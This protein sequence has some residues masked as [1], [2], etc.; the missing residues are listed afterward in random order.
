MNTMALYIDTMGSWLKC[1]IRCEHG[2]FISKTDL[3]QHDAVKFNASSCF[4]LINFAS[5][6]SAQIAP[7]EKQ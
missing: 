6:A 1:I 3:L 7:A 4:R 5:M 2:E